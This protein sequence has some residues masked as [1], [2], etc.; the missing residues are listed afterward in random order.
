MDMN[1]RKYDVIVFGATGFTGALVAEYFAETQALEPSKWAIAGRNQNKLE[2]VKARLTAIN[3]DCA[4]VDIITASSNHYE[5]LAL[6]VKQTKIVV[7]T[8]GPYALH[9]ELLVKACAEQGTHYL[10]ITGEPN[11]VADMLEKYDAVARKNNALIINCC[12]FDSIP[13]DLGAFYARSQFDANEAVT[14]KCFV[15]TKGSFSGGTWASALN[16][17][18]EINKRKSN[19]TSSKRKSTLDKNIHFDKNYKRWAVPMPVIDPW[20]VQRSAASRPDVYGKD[21]EY[22]QYLGIKNLPSVIGLVGGVGLIM[23]G[24]QLK[25]TRELLMKFKPSGE[26]PTKS[27]RD[28]GFFELTF[29][30]TSASKK[31]TTTITG[32]KDP[33]YAETSKM[34]AES[35]LTVLHHYEDLAIKSGVVT[36]AGALGNH[37]LNRLEKVNI[38]CKVK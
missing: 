34:L 23:A 14:V 9:G 5:T 7:T 30:A 10:D 17:M 11:F 22:G 31:I 21:F 3:S 20:M 24:A 25:F 15:K 8:V 38:V 27:E 37:L 13:A 6:M 4:E 33:G 12:G 26:G 19:K 35:A 2:Q 29:F 1:N 28:N 32:Q 36:P 18:A 16:A